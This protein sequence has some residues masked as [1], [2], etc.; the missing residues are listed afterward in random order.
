MF[1]GVSRIELHISGATSLKEKR[2]VMKS[3]AQ[4][5]GHRFNVSVAETEH[6]DLMQRGTLAVA[7]VSINRREVEK[8]L[9]KITEFAEANARAE[10]VRCT[11]TFFDPEKDYI[12]E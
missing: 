10:V 4:R 5:I 11:H 7:H 6:Q 3:L 1:V 12:D 8:V 2:Q 9:Q